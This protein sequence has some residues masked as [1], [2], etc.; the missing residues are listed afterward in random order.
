VL[1]AVE[2]RAWMLDGAT[3]DDV[4][5]QLRTDAENAAQAE[6]GALLGAPIDIDVDVGEPHDRLA[7]ASPELGLLVCGSR[8]YGPQPAALLGGVTGRLVAGAACAVIVTARGATVR[9]DALVA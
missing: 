1:T 6:T 5:A 9:L 7:A 2:P 8:G 3:F 4:A